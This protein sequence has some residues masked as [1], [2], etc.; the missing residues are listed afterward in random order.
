LDYLED[1]LAPIANSVAEIRSADEFTKPEPLDTSRVSIRE[2]VRKRRVR[3]L[4]ADGSTPGTS[5][6]RR[7]LELDARR[8]RVIFAF[9]GDGE[10]SQGSGFG[11]LALPSGVVEDTGAV[12]PTDPCLRGPG[13]GVQDQLRVGSKQWQFGS[14]KNSRLRRGNRFWNVS[15]RPHRAGLLARPRCIWFR[16]V[17]E[18]AVGRTKTLDSADHANVRSLVTRRQPS[19]FSSPGSGVR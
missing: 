3:R 10:N 13:R 4:A 16:V 2:L 15:R 8:F 17:L 14:C 11:R 12:A 5:D 1:H 9:L 19:L 7:F 6:C 18:L